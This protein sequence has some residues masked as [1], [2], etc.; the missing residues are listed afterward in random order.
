MTASQSTI[1]IPFGWQ[2]RT[3]KIGFAREHGYGVEICVF[4]GGDAVDDP[5]ARAE[6]ERLVTSKLRRFPGPLSMHGAFMD[7][8]VHSGD[9]HIACHSRRRII[10]DIRLAGRL[11][12][13]KVVFHTGFNPLVPSVKYKERFLTAHA[14]FWQRAAAHCPA[15]TICLENQW[16]PD[17]A[18]LKE[19]MRR[20][21]RP[22]VRLCL[23]VAHAHAYST[24]PV[25]TWLDQLA[26]HVAHMH[27]NDN[28]GDTDSHLAIGT[29]T[30]DWAALAA[31]TRRLEVP[32]SIVI[33]LNSLNAIQQS[34]SYLAGLP[35][36][37]RIP[38][39]LLQPLHDRS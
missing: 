13:Q 38:A 26:P 9:S 16:E 18:I 3:E 10:E 17:P 34:L 11:G 24:I 31:R 2:Q 33:E 28:H 7:L 21:D 15:L 23:D 22:N 4:A 32:V 30:I 12:C 6:F 5:C 35:G 1:H 8:A 19:L 37:E 25:L 27:W 39:A 14:A 36:L 20:I 29:G